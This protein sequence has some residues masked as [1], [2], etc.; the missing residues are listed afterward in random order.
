[1]LF[2]Q[3]LSI[4]RNEDR[5]TYCPGD[6]FR[7]MTLASRIF[8]ED[9]LAGTNHALLAVARSDLH[10]S[11]EINDVLPAWCGCQSRS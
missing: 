4:D 2:E 8:N 6:G 5:V 1:M 3:L 10:A 11:V 9:H 7:Q